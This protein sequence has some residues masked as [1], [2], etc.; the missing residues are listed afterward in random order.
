MTAS[1]TWNRRSDAQKAVIRFHALDSIC[2][3]PDFQDVVRLMMSLDREQGAVT[4]IYC[5]EVKC[6]NEA[7]S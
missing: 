2:F 7:T 3:A 4:L 6:S 1:E 5:P